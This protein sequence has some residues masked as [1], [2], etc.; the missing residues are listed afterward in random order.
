MPVNNRLISVDLKT[1]DE[2]QLASSLDLHRQM[3]RE[4]ADLEDEV[5]VSA[6]STPRDGG[7]PALLVMDYGR[8]FSI[9][10]L[11]IDGQLEQLITKE[12]PDGRMVG[13]ARPSGPRMVRDWRTSAGTG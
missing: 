5:V 10:T 7:N 12:I 8:T 1:G 4:V 13:L 6:P 2:R 3:R 9:A 11:S